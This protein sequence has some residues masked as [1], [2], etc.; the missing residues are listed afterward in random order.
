[1]KINK[2]IFEDYGNN[3]VE[4]NNIEKAREFRNNLAEIDDVIIDDFYL[5]N[6][7]LIFKADLGSGFLD[8]KINEDKNF[9]EAIKL[10]KK[11]NLEKL[12]TDKDYLMEVIDEV[13]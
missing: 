10:L 12:N 4:F 6:D 7:N 1:M 5:E 2:I 9:K 11:I 8:L 3:K 13:L